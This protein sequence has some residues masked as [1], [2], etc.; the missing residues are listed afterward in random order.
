MK[1]GEMR[2]GLALDHLESPDAAADVDPDPVGAGRV[3]FQARALEGEVG[4]RDRELDEPPGSLD[5][6]LLE[7]LLGLE[8]SDLSGDSTGER[9]GV[10]QA[11]L[12]NA[13]SPL[14]HGLPALLGPDAHGRHQP[15]TCYHN[16]ARQSLTPSRRPADRSRRYS[17]TIL[18]SM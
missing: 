13:A 2:F 18:A 17:L 3:D 7:V 1:K 8:A 11:D 14:Q 5:L 15:H 16:P 4:C 9:R 6:F 12:G 10:E